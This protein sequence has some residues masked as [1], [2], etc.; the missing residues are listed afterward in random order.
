M[1]LEA[2]DRADRLEPG[3]YL[4]VIAIQQAPRA[5]LAALQKSLYLRGIYLHVLR[6]S[7]EPEPKLVHVVQPTEM[8]QE[9]VK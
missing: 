9:V 6:Y 1:T 7:G 2:T 4:L 8:E 5:E 3:D